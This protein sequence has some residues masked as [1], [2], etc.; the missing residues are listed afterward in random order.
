MRATEQALKNRTE[1]HGASMDGSQDETAGAMSGKI[2]AA[3]IWGAKS[4]SAPPA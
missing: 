2:V 1:H 4:I 3:G